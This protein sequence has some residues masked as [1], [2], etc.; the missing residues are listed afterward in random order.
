MH[1]IENIMQNSMEQINRLAD[2][3]T[4]VGE[5]IDVG[6]GAVLL[7]VSKVSLG[8]TVGGGEYDLPGGKKERQG[9]DGN[10][11]FAGVSAVGM[12]LKPLA[13]VSMEQGN[14][15]QDCLTDRLLDLVPQVLKSLDRLASAVVDNMEKKC[16][17][18]SDMK[19]KSFEACIE[20]R[21]RCCGAAEGG[22]EN[23]E[24]AGPAGEAE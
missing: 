7:P 20:E 18:K 11:P 6:M 22:R 15:Q 24:S 21:R 12:C 1:P 13:F 17:N 5:A 8:F 14:I 4:V 19:R 23:E 10:Y 2:V 9:G 16:E 3:N